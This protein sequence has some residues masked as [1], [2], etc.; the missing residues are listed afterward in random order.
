[1]KI[2][3][4]FLVTFVTSGILMS[5]CLT[6]GSALPSTFFEEAGERQEGKQQQE[7]DFEARERADGSNTSGMSS[8]EQRGSGRSN[9]VASESASNA[10]E[11]YI[12]QLF[13]KSPAEIEEEMKQKFLSQSEDQ[14]KELAALVLKRAHDQL[15][16]ISAGLDERPDFENS[17]NTLKESVSDMQKRIATADWDFFIRKSVVVDLYYQ[18]FRV[19]TT[20]P[21]ADERIRG[22]AEIARPDKVS[23]PSASHEAVTPAAAIVS[24]IESSQARRSGVVHEPFQ[25]QPTLMKCIFDIQISKKLFDT[26]KT[27]ISAASASD[28]KINFSEGVSSVVRSILVRSKIFDNASPNVIKPLQIRK[29]DEQEYEPLRA[30]VERTYRLEKFLEVPYPLSMKMADSATGRLPL[31]TC[32]G[33][34]HLPETAMQNLREYFQQNI[35]DRISSFESED[36]LTDH[37]SESMQARLSE[38]LQQAG[39]MR[40]FGSRGGLEQSEL[41]NV[42]LVHEMSAEEESRRYCKMIA[43]CTVIAVAACY[44][45]LI[46]SSQGMLH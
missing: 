32:E 17:Y 34:I 27:K 21:H 16:E 30:S 22:L 1:M 41:Q 42:P 11:D 29:Y 7:A 4:R 24:A 26:I 20:S 18:K 46:M 2:P 31:L 38:I 37:L 43:G 39:P 23:N 19:R 44:V 25:A 15:N 40:I 13:K 35:P 33:L 8:E 45:W 10:D 9:I 14:Q 28:V 12:E 5:A 3:Q 36:F 6:S